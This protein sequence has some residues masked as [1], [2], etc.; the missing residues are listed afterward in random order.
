M[1][2]LILLFV[3]L[4]GTNSY[5]ANEEAT[6]RV[7]GNHAAYSYY[8]ERPELSLME[9][10]AI[11]SYN[12]KEGVDIEQLF[13]SFKTNKELAYALAGDPEKHIP[14]WSQEGLEQLYARL[15]SGPWPFG[16][17][18]EVQYDGIAAFEP[19]GMAKR[20][21]D[22]MMSSPILSKILNTLGLN[23][24]A[25]R[26]EL[27]SKM[28]PALWKGK[29]FRQNRGKTVHTLVNRLPSFTGITQALISRGEKIKTQGKGV[30]LLGKMLGSGQ[31]W[32]MMPAKVYCGESILDTR[33]E[34]FVIDYAFSENVVVDGQSYA[35]A[36][37]IPA[38][39]IIPGRNGIEIRD[40][41]R[42]VRPGI[43]LGRALV[44]RQFLLTFVLF[45]DTIK[46][47]GVDACR[48]PYSTRAQNMAAY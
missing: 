24:Q 3:A 25:A 10:R 34:S 1:R 2:N 7:D 47:T 9:R 22:L 15:S 32:L 40:E 45:N 19:E 18:D 44:R 8:S 13:S 16:D 38:H 33:K 46:V 28:T 36:A 37:S 27:T 6:L 26:L 20:I 17:K 42:M 30:P 4:L 31:E 35:N 48:N 14:G 23:S 5:A 43:Y 29:V 12:Q 39:R 41:I 21:D 11:P